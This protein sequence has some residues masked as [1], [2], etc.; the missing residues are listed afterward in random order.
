MFQDYGYCQQTTYFTYIRYAHCI[1]NI[2]LRLKP[3]KVSQ[4]Y[5]GFG[6]DEI[7]LVTCDL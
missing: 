5:P 2:H 7:N 4:G 1:L 6:D 3:L